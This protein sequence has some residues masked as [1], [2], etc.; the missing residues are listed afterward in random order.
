MSNN[1]SDHFDAIV[2]G[3]GQASGAM[4]QALVKEGKRVAVVERSRVGGS[5]VNYGCTPTKTLLASGRV[6]YL[7][8]RSGDYGIETG[9]VRVDMEQVKARKD[10]VVEQFR[11]GSVNQL[12][13]TE[14]IEL[15]R[16]EAAFSGSKSLVIN[17]NDGGQRAISGELIFINAG[18]SSRIPNIEGLDSVDF[19]TNVSLLELSEVPDHLIVLGGGYIG[20]EFSQMYRR[21]GAR[22]TIVQRGS[23]LLTLED[24]DVAS[25][26]ASILE[27][28]GV[29][30]L[31]DSEAVGVAQMDGQIELTVKKEG[32]EQ[33]VTGSHLLVAIGRV[34]NTEALRPK[35]AGIELDNKGYIQVDERLQTSA[36]GVYALGDIKGGPAFTHI[37]YDDFRVV[38]DNLLQGGNRTIEERPVPYCV[39]IDP[40]LG[41]VGMTE[42][43]AR[44]AGHDVR[45]AR[46]PMTS[47]ARAIEQGETRGFMK[48]VVDGDSDQILGCAILG[49]MGGEIMS[50]IQ[51]AMMGQLPWQRIKEGVFAHPT[52][53]ESLNNLKF[54]D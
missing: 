28:D 20:V 1:S 3:T 15:I 12:E 26:V 8:R 17:L 42:S 29:E 23:Q 32:K 13:T 2:V 51:V 38:R 50:L 21:F 37:A 30:V 46:L 19:L 4:A 39:F 35:E 45:V 11:S 6:A 49:I 40:E 18:T 53:S 34:P 54:E 27:E 41:R 36:E 9:D 47:A 10:E 44:E 52:L 24:D 14:E 7:A 48:V 5:C 25:E 22:V 43:Q 33:V 31:L 16:G